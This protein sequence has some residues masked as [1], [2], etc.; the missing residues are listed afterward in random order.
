MTKQ[1]LGLIIVMVF[2]STCHSFTELYLAVAN[3]NK[4][5]ERY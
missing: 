3:L 4:H 1:Q 5:E 2:E